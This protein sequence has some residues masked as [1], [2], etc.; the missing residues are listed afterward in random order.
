MSDQFKITEKQ[1]TDANNTF[2]L[3]DKKGNGLVSTKEL[4][5]VFKSLGLHVDGE[6]LKDWADE[7]DEEAQ[8]CI[9]WNQFKPMFEMQLKEESDERELR[10]A[11]RVLD[12]GNKGV[13]PVEDLRWLLK[14]LGDDLTEDEIEDM[15]SET[16]T[17]CSGTVDYDEFRHLM[18]N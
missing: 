5:N 9:S 8:G 11:F 7:V 14:S 15:I 18:N 1:Y 16:D 12:K 2:Q 13:I 17:D 3:F 10:E 6:N 4:P